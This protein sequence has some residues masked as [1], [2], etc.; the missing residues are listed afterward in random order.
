[1]RILSTLALA[2]ALLA[3]ASGR[4]SAAG[5]TQTNFY[6]DG[7]NLTAAQ[8]GGDVTGELDATGCDI[9]VYYDANSSQGDVTDADIFGARYFGVVVNGGNGLVAVDVTGS[10]IHRIGETPFD[11]SQHGVAVYYASVAGGSCVSGTATGTVSGNTISNYQ[12]GGIVA[13]CPGTSVAVTGNTVTGLGPVAFIAQ[14]GIQFW[15]STAT[16]LSG[17]TVTGNLYTEGAA[18]GY[19]SS[20]ILLIGASFPG[21]PG[22][23]ASSNRSYGNQANIFYI[24]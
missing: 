4:A 20:G 19:V 23:V 18:K 9:G 16:A 1:M 3:G 24:R 6:R 14:N 10:S 8:I 17:N 22:D 15:G 5:C 11:G 2:V 12:K 7:I 21:T 13:N